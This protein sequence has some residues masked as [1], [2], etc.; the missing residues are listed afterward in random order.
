MVIHGMFPGW[1]LEGVKKIPEGV[2]EH[3]IEISG[4]GIVPEALDLLQ[5]I[6]KKMDGR[7]R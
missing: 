7:H 5:R 4:H 6:A 2:E 1:R 3:Q